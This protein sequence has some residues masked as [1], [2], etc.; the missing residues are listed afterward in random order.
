MYILHLLHTKICTYFSESG[1]KNST[2]P[3]QWKKKFHFFRISK[4][5]G[6]LVEFLIPP[7]EYVR[8]ILIYEKNVRR[9]KVHHIKAEYTITYFRRLDL[10]YD[11]LKH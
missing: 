2:P 4:L 6:G 7:V 3:T 1:I 10:H 11:H 9:S 5:R 8:S